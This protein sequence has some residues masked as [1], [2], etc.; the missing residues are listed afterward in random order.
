MKLTQALAA[1]MSALVT[2]CCF[3][4]SAMSHAEPAPTG[5]SDIHPLTPRPVERIRPPAWDAAE[6]MILWPAGA[7]GLSDYKPLADIPGWPGSFLKSTPAPSLHIWRPRL[8]NGRTL[9]VIPGGG[10][11][12]VSIANEGVEIAERFAAQGYLVAVLD[13]RLPGE[14]WAGRADVPLQDAQRAIRLLRLHASD[15]GVRPDR[16]TVLGFSAGGHLAASLAVSFDEIVYGAQDAADALSA[17]PDAAALIYP[18]LS[19]EAPLAHAGSRNLLLGGS[20][21]DDLAAKRSPIRHVD[22]RTPP[23]F[24]VHSWDDDTVNPDNVLAWSTAAHAAGRPLELHLFQEGGHGYGLG[25]PGSP[26]T[27]WPD[28]LLRWLDRQFL[29]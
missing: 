14:G 16:V 5:A 26:A 28:L 4:L 25:I 3:G 17:R 18:V 11:L 22:D 9:L 12:F 15:Y 1:L 27:V 8:P 19:M 21:S 6:Q 24:L 20:P 23:S 13:Y 10:Y 29:D 2:T 7:P